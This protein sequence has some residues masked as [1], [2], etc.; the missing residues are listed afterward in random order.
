MG[1]TGLLLCGFLVTHLGGNLLMFIGDGEAYNNYAD[2]LHK[3][4]VLIKVAEVILLGLF[5]LHLYLA[6]SLSRSNRVAR[7]TRYQVQ[8]S[9]EGSEHAPFQADTWMLISGMVVL[10]FLIVHLSD[11]HFGTSVDLYTPEERA[12]MTP[13]ERAIVVL[14]NPIRVLL[15]IAGAAFLCFHLLHGFSSA[16]RSLGLSHPKY[17]YFIRGVGYFF[18]AIFGAGF[19]IFPL[20]AYFTQ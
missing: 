5:L 3:Q 19:A 9:K 14:T 11:F 7:S 20:W 1:I 16:F 10:V 17:N 8:R 18:A 12:V 15:Y 2:A 6:F 13:F 4:E